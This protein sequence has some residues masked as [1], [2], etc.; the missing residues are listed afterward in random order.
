[1]RAEAE[2]A[3]TL[4]DP[5]GNTYTVL[6]FNINEPGV[7]SFSTVEGLAFLGGVGDFPPVGVPLTVLSNSEGPT[8]PFTSLASPPCFTR[9]CRIETPNGAVPVEALTT[10]D[11]VLTADHG[12]QA[13]RWVGKRSFSAHQ[14]TRNP[15]LRPIRIMAGTLG[16]DLPKCD[17]LVSRQ[18]RMLLQSKIAQRMFGR[19]EVLVSAIKLTEL[20]GV[21]VDGTVVDIEYFHLLF[22]QHEI[23]YAAGA[24]SESLFTGPEALRSITPEAKAEV[25][26]IFPEIKDLD[27]SPRPTRLIPSGK[28]QKQLIA[29]H[30]TNNR[31]CISSEN[32]WHSQ[33]V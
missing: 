1:M 24:P 5:D 31:P 15:K 18:H 12:P 11:I 7:T 22:D 32:P 20:P 9:G 30:L 8:N 27:Y 26:S 14:L 29:R 25:L 6:G 19:H 10:G 33:V 13:I 17:I 2:Y 4:Q 21:F 16:A 3:L 28:S 23:I